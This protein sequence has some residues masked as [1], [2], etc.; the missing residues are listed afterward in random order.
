MADSSENKAPEAKPDAAIIDH[1]FA[2]GATH[3]A[4]INFVCDRFE[5]LLGG[6]VYFRDIGGGRFLVNRSP[7]ER[8]LFDQDHP[9]LGGTPRYD[10]RDGEGGIKL[11]T[12]KPEAKGA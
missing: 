5:P 6:K 1:S 2:K 3:A 9:T 7:H 12:L 10:W 4:R 11:G 8:L